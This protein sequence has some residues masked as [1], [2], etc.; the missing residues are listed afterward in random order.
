MIWFRLEDWHREADILRYWRILRL[1]IGST[2]ACYRATISYQAVH[3][4]CAELSAENLGGMPHWERSWDTVRVHVQQLPDTIYAVHRGD[5]ETE[6]GDED[7]GPAERRQFVLTKITDCLWIGNSTDAVKADL[8]G[9]GI[10]AL[11]NC[12]HDLEGERGW[13]DHVEYAQCGLVDG[14]GNTM[15]AYHAAVMKLAALVMGGR[16]PLVYDHE[17]HSQSVAITICVLHILN[18]RRGWDY[19]RSFIVERGHE[20][21]DDK[22]HPEHLTAFNR[23]NWRVLMGVLER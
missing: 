2:E 13:N 11:M 21:P 7:V 12:A 3:S 1:H 4:G 9:N 18:G 10:S 8:H 15:M 19:W 17:G 6:G 14:P 16:K 5:G 23:I 20:L 22:P